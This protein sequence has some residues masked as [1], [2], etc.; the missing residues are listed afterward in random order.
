MASSAP[1]CGSSSLS[2]MIS[3]LATVA[4]LLCCAAVASA[5][6]GVVTHLTMG[7]DEEKLKPLRCTVEAAGV[8]FKALKQEGPW[9]GHMDKVG[10]V[11]L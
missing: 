10:H 7:D 9:T 2:E 5:N 4:V 11:A 8:P 1:R 3:R 6:T